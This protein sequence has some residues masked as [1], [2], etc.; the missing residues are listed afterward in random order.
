MLSYETLLL[1]AFAFF[2]GGFV[3]GV[4]GL[5]V[6]VVVLAILATTVGLKETMALL[7]VPTI[8]MNLWQ[9]L[10]GGNFLMLVR[11]LWLKLLCAS[12][13]IW[14]GVE[15]LVRIDTHWMVLGL[16]IILFV[17]AVLSLRRPQIRPPGKHESWLSPVVG[18]V[19]GLLLVHLAHIWCP[20]SSIFRR[21][22]LPVIN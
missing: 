5:G 21:L 4:V 1:V 6:P 8:A 11:R 7:L 9:A 19:A 14:L 17:Y 18:V 2:L 12:L 15:V 3:K 16:G 10:A 13:G 22:V 20:V